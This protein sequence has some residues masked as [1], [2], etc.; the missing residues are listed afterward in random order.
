MTVPVRGAESVFAATVYP[1][2]PLPTPLVLVEETVIHAS[3]V[4]ASQEH[5]VGDDTL[6]LPV[7]PA[8]PKLLLVGVIE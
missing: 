1:T 6:M 5:S 8:E 2:V 4:L 7:P 3:V